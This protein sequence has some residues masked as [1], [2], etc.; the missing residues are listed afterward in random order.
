M[1]Y[2]ASVTTQDADMKPFHYIK[3][4]IERFF[5]NVYQRRLESEAKRVE[6][7]TVILV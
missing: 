5:Y 1:P 7:P 3:N 6:Y 2:I 4:R